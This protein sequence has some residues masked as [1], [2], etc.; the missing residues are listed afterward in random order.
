MNRRHLCGW[1]S[2]GGSFGRIQRCD[3]AEG[4]VFLGMGFEN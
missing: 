1:S 4:G 2:D 3:L